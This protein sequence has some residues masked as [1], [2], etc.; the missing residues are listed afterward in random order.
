MSYDNVSGASD[1]LTADTDRGGGQESTENSL[2]LALQSSDFS[3]CTRSDSVAAGGE[4][5]SLDFLLYSLSFPY[6]LHHW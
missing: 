5:G 4:G 6:D 1:L 3:V 2:Q